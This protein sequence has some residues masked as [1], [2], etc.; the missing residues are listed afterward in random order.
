M[1]LKWTWL[2]D[3]HVM[4]NISINKKIF[5]ALGLFI[6]YDYVGQ[7]KNKIDKFFASEYS[8]GIFLQYKVVEVILTM[9]YML[10]LDCIYFS[11]NSNPKIL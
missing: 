7:I 8:N 10:L 2:I 4:V 11:F 1:K 3:Q 9:Y 5:Y 6:L